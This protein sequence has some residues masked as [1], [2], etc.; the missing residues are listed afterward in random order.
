MANF[1]TKDKEK[2]LMEKLE[3]AVIGK[4]DEV[5][6]YSVYYE[7]T[8]VAPADRETRK[9]SSCGKRRSMP[10]ENTVSEIFDAETTLEI[11]SPQ[12]W[13]M[14]EDLAIKEL[15]ICIKCMEAAQKR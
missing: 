4:L 9:C 5:E 7:S 8:A 11:T 2:M 10:I 15:S 6:Q 13:D 14:I 12:K 3:L 1:S